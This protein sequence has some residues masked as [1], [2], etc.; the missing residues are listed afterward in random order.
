MMAPNKTSEMVD[1]HEATWSSQTD[2]LELES[3]ESELKLMAHKIL[4]PYGGVAPNWNEIQAS[5]AVGD[6]SEGSGFIG[7]LRNNGAQGN[8]WGMNSGSGGSWVVHPLV[9]LWALYGPGTVQK[10][11]ESE[12]RNQ[13]VQTPEPQMPLIHG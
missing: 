4:R 3:L 6:S 2:D 13:K 7:K 1:M 9:V 5:V 12:R 8:C 11:K 10:K